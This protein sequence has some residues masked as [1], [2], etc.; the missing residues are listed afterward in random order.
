MATSTMLTTALTNVGQSP[1]SAGC[2]LNDIRKKPADG[3]AATKAASASSRLRIGA[4]ASNGP[5][6]TGVGPHAVL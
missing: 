4:T 1:G 2:P 3:I 6:L 5:K